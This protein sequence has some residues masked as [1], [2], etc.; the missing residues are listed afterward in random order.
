M[1]TLGEPLNGGNSKGPRN[2]ATDRAK[3]GSKPWPPPAFDA[4]NHRK[5]TQ[6]RAL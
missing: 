5:E 1:T 6:G 4:S 2:F 3:L